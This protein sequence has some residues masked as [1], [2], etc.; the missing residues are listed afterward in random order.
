MIGVSFATKG[1][2]EKELA[3]H[4]MPSLKKFNIPYDIDIIPKSNWK[5]ATRY[6][7]TLI[8]KKL[9]KH[10]KPIVFLDVDA[11]ILKYPKL[12]DEISD[13]DISIHHLDYELQWRKRPGKRKDALTGTLYFN[14]TEKSLKFVDEWIEEI[15]KNGE[16]DQTNIQYLLKRNK[17]LKIY[18]LPYSYITIIMQRGEMPTHMI[19]REDIYILHHQASRRLKRK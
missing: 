13:Y 18:P 16:H 6:K 8:K 5:E 7:A 9:L 19:R 11:Q 12:F 4:L 15:K 3:Y 14:Y 17:D 1:N 10:K 2:Y